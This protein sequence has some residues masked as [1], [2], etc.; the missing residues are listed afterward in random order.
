M[1]VGAAR[2]QV[3]APPRQLLR[4]R[5]GIAYGLMAVFL[6]GGGGGLLERDADRGGGMVVRT[7]LQARKDRAGDAVSDFLAAQNHRAARAAQGFVDRGGDDVGMR[8]RIRMG[9]GDDQTGD[10]RKS[11]WRGYAVA[12]ATIICGRSRRARSR[13]AS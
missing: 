11:S 5:L 10:V 4:H 12:P 1:V 6:E 9:S 7:A 3:E 2:Y 8:N 13:T